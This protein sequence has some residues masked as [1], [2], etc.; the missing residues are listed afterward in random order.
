MYF[1]Y[2]LSPSLPVER[3]QDASE[4]AACCNPYLLVAAHMLLLLAGA[5]STAAGWVDRWAYA[6]DRFPSVWFGANES[7]SD[8]PYLKANNVDKYAAVYFGWQAG[9]SV[10]GC[11]HEE[12]WLRNQ[13]AAVKA[14]K[15][16][17]NTLAYIGNGASVLDFYDAQRRITHDP[18][19]SGYFLSKKM[20]RDADVDVDVDSE[21]GAMMAGGDCPNSA[22][23]GVQPT[24]DFRNA[25]AVDYFVE[26]VV[27]PW[28]QDNVTDSVFID[29]GDSVACYGHPALPN[30]EE[31][32]RWSNGSLDAY[33]RSAAML[34]ARG[35]RLIVSLK[36]GFVGEW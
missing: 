22:R 4:T 26:H 7:G 36:N 35:K 18:A 28:A 24:W 1:E 34:N 30:L 9:N 27:G 3:R 10:T 6:A 15:P 14:L 31:Q 2:S 29:E 23:A 19:F 13:T 32:F 5:V 11:R 12:A 16:T 20:Q 21:R 33:R 17:I 8:A 25:S